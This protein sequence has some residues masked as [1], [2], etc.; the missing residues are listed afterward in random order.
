[1]ENDT[2]ENEKN[3]A[4]V[5]TGNEDEVKAEVTET[6]VNTE[7]ESSA[8]PKKEKVKKKWSFRSIS[9]GK[10]DKQKPKREKKVEEEKTVAE[11]KTDESMKET[12]AEESNETSMK[13]EEVKEPSL[14]P[15][16]AEEVSKVEEKIEIVSEESTKKEE[17]L[18]K[19]KETVE[20]SSAPTI[21]VAAPVEEPEVAVETPV[22]P[23]T[24][25]PS[26][27]SVF[28]E[29]LTNE[30]PTTTETE[31]KDEEPESNQN[32]DVAPVALMVEKVLE[33]AV[34][35]VQNEVSQ[36]AD[37][38]P[39]PPEDEVEVSSNTEENVEETLPEKVKYD[40]FKNNLQILINFWNFKVTESSEENHTD[41]V[42]E[43]HKEEKI[44]EDIIA[45]KIVD[46]SPE[47]APKII[48]E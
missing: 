28:A 44:V 45:E 27:A 7:S 47:I 2:I 6:P 16:T 19:I 37:D 3:E 32:I 25:P 15:T 17:Q 8:P 34:E 4:E 36:D 30:E 5:A 38:L 23:T 12:V 33:D 43:V 29:K 1:M 9:F 10:K 20:E 18:E 46:D 11:E 26:Q 31:I 41:N 14:V 22:L 21:V 42:E 39:A 40:I 13:A 35:T 24:P 48:S